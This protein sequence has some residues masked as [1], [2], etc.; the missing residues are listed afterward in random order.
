MKLPKLY[1]TE[2]LDYTLH[3]VKDDNSSKTQSIKCLICNKTTTCKIV[4]R[5]VKVELIFYN[6]FERSKGQHTQTASTS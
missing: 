3:E 4:N 1:C 5:R 6:E 2:C